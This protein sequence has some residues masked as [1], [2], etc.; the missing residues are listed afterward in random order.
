MFDEK[1]CL[2]N[3]QRIVSETA[4]DRNI[5]K[6]S[7]DALRSTYE[8]ISGN[9]FQLSV[10]NCHRFK[11]ML[12][13]LDNLKPEIRSNFKIKCFDAWHAVY[14]KLGAHDL[15]QENT[16]D[17]KEIEIEAAAY[18]SD[19]VDPMER[20]IQ[21]PMSVTERTAD[22]QKQKP[23]ELK[24]YPTDHK[25]SAYVE[26]RDWFDKLLDVAVAIVYSFAGIFGR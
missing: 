25:P 12:W 2:E 5:K 7:S 6:I 14:L 24:S 1:I 15:A 18:K 8:E 10:F 4:D 13:N 17:R 21:G 26:T 3:L 9:I 23:F 16:E 19:P 22:A 20:E 11:N